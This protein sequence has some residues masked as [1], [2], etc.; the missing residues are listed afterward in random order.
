MPPPRRK[1]L[2]CG[3]LQP[4]QL[5]ACLEELDAS[6]E[7]D[8][9]WRI[10]SGVLSL[11]AEA[12]EECLEGMESAGCNALQFTLGSD[13]QDIFEITDRCERAEM[14]Q[15]RSG[16]GEACADSSDCKAG[17]CPA[18]D[19]ECHRCQAFAA[20]GQACQAGRSVC[21]PATA[22]CPP[23][24]V[25]HGLASDGAR[26]TAPQECLAHHCRLNRD[27]GDRQCGATQAGESCGD[28][29]DCS[30][31]QFCLKAS[32]KSA[33]AVRLK[34][35]EGC[36]E[37]PA[38]C[39]DPE[40]QCVAGR[41]GVRPFVLPIDARCRDFTDCKDGLYCKAERCAPHATEGEP[42]DRLDYG[43]C[44]A[45]AT[46][47]DGRCRR[48][49]A[50]GGKCSGPS[51]CTAFSS[52]V[53]VSVGVGYGS[54]ATCVANPRS[55]ETCNEYLPCAASVCDLSLR[56]DPK[57]VSPTAV[58]TGCRFSEQCASGWCVASADG[59][60]CYG[61]CSALRLK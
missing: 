11:N 35:G 47:L 43:A 33:C 55:G 30:A 48:L 4:R 1:R 9:G 61:H 34:N 42:C 22:W 52:C 31:G 6:C 60:V 21:D 18:L 25:C 20:I 26:C 28:V 12:R 3:Q 29:G 59:G 2:D 57:C 19:P 15:A 54:G 41:C 24:S 50:V 39:A 23:D 16:L 45:D 56:P 7:R 13:E 37:Q 46:C 8:L 58:G 40:A 14:F 17:F 5:D 32:G 53:P 36:V 49:V 44:R 10:R 38:A 27:G 51:Q